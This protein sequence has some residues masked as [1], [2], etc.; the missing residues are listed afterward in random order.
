MGDYGFDGAGEFP[1]SDEESHYMAGAVHG[2]LKFE[3]PKEDNPEPEKVEPI[4]PKFVPKS[5]G[6]EK[7]LC[8]NDMYCGK[9]LFVAQGEM[10]S[11]H[12][13]RKKHE[14]MYIQSG[15]IEMQFLAGV[16]SETNVNKEVVE[17]ILLEEG[18]SV[19][20]PA[21]KPH[22]FMAV[23][24]TVIIETSTP[25]SDEDVVRIDMEG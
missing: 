23:Y 18:D 8:N 22:R 3:Q 25:H 11:M 12:Y 2:P 1:G 24:D 7:W 21:F 10:G 14:D 19:H 6:Y 17:T 20:I 13:H 16:E 4:G 15:S 5:W 9:I